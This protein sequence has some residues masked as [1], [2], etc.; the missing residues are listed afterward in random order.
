[1]PSM[2][3]TRTDVSRS[4]ADILPNLVATLHPETGL[5]T[6]A[7]MPGVPLGPVQSAIL[8]VV[9]GLGAQQLRAAKPYARFLTAQKFPTLQSVFPSTTA[10]SLTAIMTGAWPGEHGVVGYEMRDAQH[11]RIVNGLTG[12]DERMVPETWQLREPL[13]EHAGRLGLRPFAVGTG[14]Y[15]TS[16]MTR[17]IL[18][19]AT[20]VPADRIA[21]RFAQAA[22]L[23]ETPG[24]L[25][26]LYVPELD[27]IAHRFGVADE[28]WLAALEDLDAE[29]RKLHARVGSGV[30]IALSADHG[31]VDVPD[32]AHVLFD[33][34]PDLVAGIGLI[35]GE[36]R[37]RHLYFDAGVSPER[38]AATLGAWQES[39]GERA[40]VLSRDEAI[41]AGLF[42]TVNPTVVP[43]IGDV[44]VA[45]RKRIA[46]Y[47]SRPTDQSSRR[48]VGQH[49]SLTED[50]VLVPWITLGAWAPPGRG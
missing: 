10:A 23:A 22:K 47:D 13:F 15:A 49:G 17:A 18:R 31:I 9:D 19:G 14:K 28:R 8:I 3:P 2:L 4:Q 43:R 42:G 27:Q 38:R 45:A 37:M 25:V 33:Q 41:A 46:Y 29:V 26:Y 6:P 34:D 44:L 11:D 36:P 16:G 32:Y 50:E 40:W 12:W 5:P 35:G 24:A 7:A 39:E 20:Y 21:E 48:M 1:M 30:G